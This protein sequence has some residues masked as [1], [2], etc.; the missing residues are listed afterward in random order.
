MLKPP[1]VT[2]LTPYEPLPLPNPS[3]YDGRLPSVGP[4]RR[5]SPISL[6]KSDTFQDSLSSTIPSLLSFSPQHSA[7]PE[8]LPCATPPSDPLDSLSKFHSPLVLQSPPLTNI[9]SILD[10]IERPPPHILGKAAQPTRTASTSSG[11]ISTTTNLQTVNSPSTLLD[12]VVRNTEYILLRSTDGTVEA[13]TLEGL[14]D[15][16]LKETHDRA[17]DDEFEAVFLAT[18]RLFT[19]DENLFEIL[20]RHFEDIGVSDPKNLSAF[21]GSIRHRCVFHAHCD[22]GFT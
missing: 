21:R 7:T 3:L 8:S 2:G 12:S 13:G 10:R 17:K 5:P 6:V 18:Y 19:T 11:S 14:V 9:S 22:V 4:F 1:T 16:L 15:R 20:K